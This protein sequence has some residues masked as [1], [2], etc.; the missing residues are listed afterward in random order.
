MWAV[1]STSF[2]KLDASCSYL[3]SQHPPKRGRREEGNS[4]ACSAAGGEVLR[5]QLLLL[6]PSTPHS[7]PMKQRG[8]P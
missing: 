2:H 3:E 8:A 6:P 1:C 4:C 7:Y 5:G